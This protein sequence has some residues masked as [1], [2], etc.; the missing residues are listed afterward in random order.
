VRRPL[1]AG[2]LALGLVALATVVRADDPTASTLP[3]ALRDVGIDR[4][5]GGQLPLELPLVDE[6]GRTVHLRDYFGSR[7]VIVMPVYYRCPMLCPIA[8]EGLAR[9]LKVLAFGAK[10]DYELVVFS[11]NPDEGPA[12]ARKKK[13]DA[14]E[15]YDGHR[16]GDRGWHFLTADRQT[17]AALTHALGFRYTYDQAKG[18]FVHASTLVL[19]TPDGKIARYLY[20]T[21][22]APKDLRLAL[23]EASAGKLGTLADQVLLYC[24]HYDAASG[25]YTLLTMRL[26]RIGA[27]VTVLGLALMI[28]LLL[29]QERRGARER[30]RVLEGLS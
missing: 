5:I 13:A 15:Y 7:P 25:R 20:T 6:Q 18:Q 2:A 11:F 14:L 29:R 8:L 28:G 21:E 23:I 26:L 27:A 30:A 9:S 16:F 3:F 10:T 22:P 19:A 24:Y 12:D 4:H 17:I 1:L